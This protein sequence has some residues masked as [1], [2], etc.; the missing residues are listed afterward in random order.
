MSDGSENNCTTSVLS[1]YTHSSSPPENVKISLPEK[2]KAV[3]IAAVNLK[4]E[5]GD[6]VQWLIKLELV[7]DSLA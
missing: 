3:R 1:M 7:L 4:R 6:R 2:L 5:D